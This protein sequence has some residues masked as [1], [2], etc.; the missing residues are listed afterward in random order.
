MALI[1]DPDNLNQL[2]EVT[3][4]TALKTITL[5]IAGLLSADGVTGQAL[6]SFLKEEWKADA[7]LIPYPFPMVS[8]TQEQ[9]EFVDD[10]EPADVGTRNLIR[11]AGWRE[12]TAAD[13]I[14][15][16]YAGI[17][18]LGNIDAA[19]TAY[20]AFAGDVAKTD[21]DYTGTINQGIQTF[22]DVTNGN[23]D[24]RAN[25]LTIYIRAQ[26]KTF[27]NSTSTAIG[28]TSLG[29][30][31]Y[32]FPLAEAADIKVVTADVNIAADAPFTGMTI[33]YGAITRAIGGPSYNFDILIEGNGGTKEQIY[34]FVQYSLRLDSDVDAG[35]GTVNGYLANELLAFVGDTLKTT[36]GVYI[37]NFSADD[38]NDIVFTDTGG[39]E[40]SFPFVAT[41]NLLFNPN[42]SGDADA[43]VRMF[44]ADNFGTASAL[45]VQDDSD[46]D[47]SYNIA[48]NTSIGFTFD[49]DGNVQGGRTFGT[50]ALVEVVAI[51]L[52]TGQYVRAQATIERKKAQNISLVAPLERNYS[53]L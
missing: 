28:V 30:I 53:N 50:D 24:D 37:D 21:F 7:A 18:S 20:Y 40:R 39:T 41:G 13:A 29:Y 2:T 31:A 15:R 26:A 42:L 12:L 46:V 9:F 14:K 8:I 51:G 43:V 22:G 48:S 49:Y 27:G 16:E 36:L 23:F 35:A 1:T 6:Y 17:I 5:N 52:S 19:D 3:I 47:I 11:S 45:I 38:T 34:E 32:R 10:W 4:N 44:F 25:E 33:T